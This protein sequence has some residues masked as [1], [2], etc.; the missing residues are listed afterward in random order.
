MAGG[1]T[2]TG[3]ALSE[4]A[5]HSVSSALRFYGLGKEENLR[6]GKD[7]MSK[8]ARAS[9]AW[10]NLIG[11]RGTTTTST[12]RP[13]H[14]PPS[15]IKETTPEPIAIPVFNSETAAST[16]RKVGTVSSKVREAM[17]R[18]H[19]SATTLRAIGGQAA[20]MSVIASR[21]GHLLAILP[22][23]AGK[24]D[25][26]L[27]PLPAAV[28]EG[29]TRMVINLSPSVALADDVTK[30]VIRH[31]LRAIR[32]STERPGVLRTP[33]PLLRRAPLEIYR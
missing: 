8:A 17:R 33:G 16:V 9:F 2:S 4:Q 22:T 1:L 18:L 14:P 32:L 27:T 13:A 23:G 3:I 28:W 6:I 12:T 24:T 15:Y 21:M 10:H 20:A 31:G 29:T 11:M 25:V 5:S 30:Q 26:W 7:A 19:V